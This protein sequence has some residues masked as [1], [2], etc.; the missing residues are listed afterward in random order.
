M[1]H[2]DTSFLI[3][4]LAAGTAEARRLDAWCAAR[5]PL[6]VSAVAWAE[7]A[8]GPLAPDERAAV[9]DV[10]DAVVPLEAAGGERA[11]ALFNATGRRRSSFHDCLIAAVALE[12]GA[13]V[14]TSNEADFR[15]FLA[16]GLVIAE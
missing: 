3:R 15:R 7:F 13:A 16:H 14:A 10:I 5:E 11:A 12:A 8:C 6:A 1:I 2:L 4:A 9:L